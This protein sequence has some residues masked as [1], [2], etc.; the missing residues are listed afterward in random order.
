MKRLKIQYNG[1]Q[2]CPSCKE[3]GIVWQPYGMKCAF[4]GYCQYFKRANTRL[5]ADT[6]ES[7]ASKGSINASAKSKS[8]ASTKRTQ[9]G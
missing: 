4:C 2:S 6:G 5:H 3:S 8:Q 7:V 1:I 9:R